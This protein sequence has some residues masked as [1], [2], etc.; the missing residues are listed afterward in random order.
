MF[1]QKRVSPHTKPIKNRHTTKDKIVQQLF[2]F[3]GL[4]FYKNTETKIN[5]KKKMTSL[6]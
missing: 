1:F 2:V 4:F 3:T 6:D 5:S